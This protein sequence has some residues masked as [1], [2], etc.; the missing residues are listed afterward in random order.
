[1]ADRISEI[2]LPMRAARRDSGIAGRRDR[3]GRR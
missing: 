1:M 3:V 2:R